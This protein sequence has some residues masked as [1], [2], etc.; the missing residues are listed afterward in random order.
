MDIVAD[1]AAGDPELDVERR[2]GLSL[3]N[4]GRRW[5]LDRQILDILGDGR[6]LRLLSAAF[7][8]AFWRGGDGILVG[9]ETSLENRNG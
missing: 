4:L 3:E 9:H 6:R 8:S 1:L 5:A 2:L 7:F